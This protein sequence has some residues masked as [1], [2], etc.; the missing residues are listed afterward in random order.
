MGENVCSHIHSLW[1]KE[2]PLSTINTTGIFLIPKIENP[3][4]VT[5]LLSIALCNAIYKMFSKIIVNRLKRHM[6]H[7]VFMNQSGFIHKRNIRENIVVAQEILHSVHRSKHKLGS[8]AIKVDLVKAYDNISWNFLDNFLSDIG[9]PEKLK[10][11]IMMVVTSI[12]L[13]VLW[14][15]DKG[16]FFEAGKGLCQGDPLS[17]IF[18]CFVW[19]SSPTSSMM[20]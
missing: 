12:S 15:G 1:N 11:L 7:I 14:K 20:M 17:P 2:S 9:F 3:H 5:Q 19:I 6:D 8:F 4:L 16:D 10:N 18:L 13:W